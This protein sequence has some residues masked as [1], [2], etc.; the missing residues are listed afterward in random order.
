MTMK[1]SKVKNPKN[2]RQG[3]IN[4]R[5]GTIFEKK[6]RE[7]LIEKGWI[8]SK[9][10]NNVEFIPISSTLINIE[11]NLIPAKHTFNP[12]S[13]VMSLGTGFPDFVAYT[14]LEHLKYPPAYEVIGVEAKIN[15]YL[16]P[17]ERKKCQWLLKNNIFG[18]I[19]IAKKGEKKGEIVY[20]EVELDGKS[21]L[22]D[23]STSG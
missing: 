4:K 23:K 13:R 10:P 3:R 20:K 12:F 21:D 5:N 15:G 9:W 16:D 8:V 22:E 7:D 6:V 1:K 11:G 19:L 17:T 18:R 2:V 14:R